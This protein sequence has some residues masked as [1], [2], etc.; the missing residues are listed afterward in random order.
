[1]AD[2]VARIIV[3]YYLIRARADYDGLLLR[4]VIRRHIAIEFLLGTY[5]L[6]AKQ[7]FTCYVCLGVDILVV[8]G[9][10]D[11]TNR[12]RIF[13]PIIVQVQLKAFCRKLAAMARPMLFSAL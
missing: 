3:E 6:C 2:V 10:I 9:R 1:M 8:V 12:V 5:H 4:L 7:S 11:I 13:Y